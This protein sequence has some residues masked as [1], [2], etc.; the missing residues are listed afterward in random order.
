MFSPGD[1]FRKFLIGSSVC[2]DQL[3]VT[4]TDGLYRIKDL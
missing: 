2:A 1:V 4:V 3:V